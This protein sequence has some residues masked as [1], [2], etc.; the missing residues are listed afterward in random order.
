MASTEQKRRKK[1]QP[2]IETT[3]RRRRFCL[4]SL[5]TQCTWKRFR[6]KCFIQPTSEWIWKV[7]INSEIDEDVEKNQ[8][9]YQ[10]QRQTRE[11]ER[12]WIKKKWFSKNIANDVKSF[13]HITIFLIV[14]VSLS[15]QQKSPNSMSQAISRVANHKTPSLH[16]T[17]PI[18]WIFTCSFASAAAHTTKNSN[19]SRILCLNQFFCP[20][21]FA[22][23]FIFSLPQLKKLLENSVILL[24]LTSLFQ[25]YIF[26][27]CT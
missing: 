16:S 2:Q 18:V 4:L 6:V 17:H 15:S 11:R 25:P 13:P 20:H 10:K 14:N 27:F 7:Q 19:E 1:N 22:H 5:S 21:F 3:R 9:K 23:H 26:F 8:R 12:E 24:N